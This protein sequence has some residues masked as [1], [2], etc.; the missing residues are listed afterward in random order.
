MIRITRKRPHAGWRFLT[1]LVCLGLVSARAQTETTPA[2]AAAAVP[3]V[4]P[5]INSSDSLLTLVPIR[6]IEE[7]KRDLSEFSAHRDQSTMEEQNGKRL[8]ERAKTEIRLKDSE[9]QTIKVNLDL[10]KKEKNEIAKSEWQS[11]KRLAELEKG[12]LERREAVRAKEI[13]YSEAARKYAEANIECRN[14]ELVLAGKRNERSSVAARALTPEVVAALQRTDRDLDDLQ[15]RTLDAQ[16]KAAEA[17]K[18]IA[19]K[20]VDLA[21]NRKKVLEAQIKLMR[22]N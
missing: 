5:A 6:G 12:L 22:G 8:Q 4:A 21:K 9:I 1:V 20:E 11:K 7:I 16:I 19:G 17:R 14:L 13:E 10:A 15:K 3:P 2:P 18:N